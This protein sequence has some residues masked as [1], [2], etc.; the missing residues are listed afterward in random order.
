MAI[1]VIS[2]LKP[3]NDANH[4]VTDSSYIKGGYQSVSTTTTRDAIPSERRSVGML[5]HVQA[6]DLF[7]KLVGGIADS[8][9]LQYA[10]DGNGYFTITPA[11]S[12]WIATHKFNH[13]PVVICI[14][15]DGRQRVGAISYPSG[16]AGGVIRVDFNSAVAG[17]GWYS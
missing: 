6:D 15:T 17:T 11:A 12:S 8:N 1:P 4:P 13:N 5:V 7:Y 2:D 14:D 16:T 3:A 10:G 9:W